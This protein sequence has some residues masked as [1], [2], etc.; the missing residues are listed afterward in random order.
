MCI[1]LQSHQN[2]KYLDK[3]ANKLIGLY[4]ENFTG[5]ASFETGSTIKALYLAGNSEQGKK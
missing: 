3:Q 4:S 2:L 1:H 5:L